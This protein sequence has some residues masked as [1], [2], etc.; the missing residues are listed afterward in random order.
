VSK[1]NTEIILFAIVLR[2]YKFVPHL[3]KINSNICTPGNQTIPET[4]MFPGGGELHLL[5]MRSLVTDA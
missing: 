2:G 3:C 5:A 1:L 4:E